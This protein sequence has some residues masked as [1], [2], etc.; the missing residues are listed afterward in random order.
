MGGSDDP[1]N[2]VELTVEEHAEAHFMLWKQYG[3]KRDFLAWAGLEGIIPKQELI[4]RLS[5][6]GATK[7]GNTHAA[8]LIS[9]SDYRVG[10]IAKWKET[11][12]AA[13]VKATKEKY[14]EG[15]WK[16]KKHKD[17]TKARIGKVNSVKQSGSGNSQYGTMWITNGLDNKKVKKDSIVPIGYRKGRVI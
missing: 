4:H 10:H 13:G 12:V 15:T 3:D 14:P 6:E 5:I 7:A 16:G 17:E 2:I 8:R 11:F 9:D 1:S